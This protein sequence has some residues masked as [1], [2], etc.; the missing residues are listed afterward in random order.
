MKTATELQRSNRELEQFAY[1]V[2]H[3]LSEPLLSERL[4]VSRPGIKTLF[5]SGYTDDAVVR[6]GVLEAEM[7][8]LQ[9]PFL[10]R[11]L[12]KKVR[13]VLDQ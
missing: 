13:E 3:D 12:A 6:H 7:A 5:L 1:V 10:P 8:F 2:S 9:K 11:A 4:A